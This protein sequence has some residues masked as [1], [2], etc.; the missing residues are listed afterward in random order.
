MNERDWVDWIVIGASVLSSLS[1]F[2]A[3][4]TYMTTSRKERNK[5]IE[6]RIKTNTSIV[7]IINLITEPFINE[8]NILARKEDMIER[9]SDYVTFKRV[10]NMYT[11]I[12]QTEGYK[13]KHSIFIP[14][15]YLLRQ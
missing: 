7:K 12:I 15:L 10:D 14:D 13:G 4:V 6:E 2:V 1:V 3:I 11:I 8:F 9:N 5:E